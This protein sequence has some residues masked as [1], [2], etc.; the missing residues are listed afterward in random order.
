[1]I[2]HINKSVHPPPKKKKKKNKIKKT[3]LASFFGGW[4]GK[5]LSTFYIDII[6]DTASMECDVSKKKCF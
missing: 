3:H 2:I 5:T 4:S 6:C 1:M